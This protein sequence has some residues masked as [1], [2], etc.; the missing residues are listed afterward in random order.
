MT[1]ARQLGLGVD[2]SER[3]HVISDCGLFRYRLGERWGNGPHVSWGMLNPSRATA[4]VDD[5][6]QLK[7]LGFT[8]RWGFSAYEIWNPFAFRA[9]YP[10]DLARAVDPVGPDN[11]GHILESVRGA[12]LVVVGWGSASSV[13]R[14]FRARRTGRL[15]EVRALLS[16]SPLRCLGQAKDGNPRHPL[17]LGY[18]TPLV[19]L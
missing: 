8:K 7:V 9:T 17:M 13:P 15:A 3:W 14:E 16:G 12:A 4:E 11:D 18:S 10:E 2:R 5:H 6:T 1:A 19:P